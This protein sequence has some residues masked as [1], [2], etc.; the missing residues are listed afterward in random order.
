M[1][2]GR[3]DLEFILRAFSNGHD[4]VFIGGCRLNECNYV[5]Q[6]NY[7]ALGNTLLCKMIMDKIGIDNERLRI[8]FMNA[9][10]GILLAESINNFSGKIKELGPI[11]MGVGEKGHKIKFKLDAARKIV[12]YLR[13]VERERLRVS[14]RSLAEYQK[15]YSSEEMARLFDELISDKIAISEIMM[16]LDKKPLSTGE[17]AELLELTPS[18]VSKHIHNSSRQGLVKYDESLKG[19][20]LA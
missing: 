13:L 16:L 6:G 5:T 3:I 8:Q 14:I 11:N 10:D 4:G 7:D 17:I 15:F 12:P 20:A 18:E 9:S 19:Y 1:C 2:S